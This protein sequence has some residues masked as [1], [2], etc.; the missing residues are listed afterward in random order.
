MQL[1]ANAALSLTQRRRLVVRIVD[2]GWSLKKAAAA[3]EISERRA[4]KWAARY[5]A[6]GEVGLLDR[7]SAPTWI[8]HRTPEDRVQVIA[9]L[10]RL[11]MTGAEIALCP[12]A[13]RRPTPPPERAESE[14][15]QGFSSRQSGASNPSDCR[16]V[17][18][19][20]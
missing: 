4:T 14:A 10:R 18:P 5:R 17:S 9:A 11:R 13:R 12:Q 8:P 2:E 1:H 16:R 6:A 3:A 20:A 19:S 7:S 15:R